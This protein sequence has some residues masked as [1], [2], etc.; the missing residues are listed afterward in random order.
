MRLSSARSV[1]TAGVSV[2]VVVAPVA[3]K[4]CVAGAVPEGA[5]VSTITTSEEVVAVFPAPSVAV[6]TTV[7][8]PRENEVGVYEIVGDAVTSSVEVARVR[9]GVVVVPVASNVCVEGAVIEGAPLSLTMTENEEVAVFPEES[10]TE[11]LTVV[12]PIAKS[13]VEVG[14]QVGVSVPS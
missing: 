8:V 13:E 12:V 7:V 4:V 9:V 5:V 10:V 1:A 2:G 14:E 11:Q 6:Q 3:S